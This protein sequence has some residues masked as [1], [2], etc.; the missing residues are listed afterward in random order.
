MALLAGITSTISPDLTGA[1]TPP[2]RVPPVTARPAV[3]AWRLSGVLALC[4]LA[5]S[6]APLLAQDLDAA[7]EL[8]ELI[9]DAAVE[10]A[11]GWASQGADADETVTP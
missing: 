1:F 4:L 9:P 8:E 11:E 5:T 3:V 2:C 10:D 6:H 7:P